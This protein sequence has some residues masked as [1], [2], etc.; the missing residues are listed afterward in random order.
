MM[1]APPAICQTVDLARLAPATLEQRR[2]AARGRLGETLYFRAGDDLLSFP[3]AY[4][5][6]VP[7]LARFGCV[8]RTREVAFAFRLSD[9]APAGEGAPEPAANGG[10]AP[11]APGSESKGSAA[12]A[13]TAK[14]DAPQSHVANSTGQATTSAAAIAS[15]GATRAVS[16]SDQRDAAQSAASGRSVQGAGPEDMV[17]RVVALHVGRHADFMGMTRAIAAVRKEE[18]RRG[19][20]YALERFPTPAGDR[21]VRISEDRCLILSLPPDPG[22]PGAVVDMRFQNEEW[23]AVVEVPAGAASRWEAV[24]A[25]IERFLA[26][27]L[28]RNSFRKS[29]PK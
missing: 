15:G 9:L 18:A 23:S 10:P 20:V 5:L 27:H 21:L 13:G 16:A 28:V 14:S 6:T 24:Y 12:I 7:D 11:V 17:V 22:A 3:A 2:A 19:F 1:D 26:V 8:A 4:A 25:G 29:P